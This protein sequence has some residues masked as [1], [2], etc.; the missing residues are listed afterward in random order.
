MVLV[1]S[2]DPDQLVFHPRSL[3]WDTL[4]AARFQHWRLLSAFFLE[5]VLWVFL[6]VGFVCWLRCN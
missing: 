4:S 1:V 5:G 2:F 3:S 6:V